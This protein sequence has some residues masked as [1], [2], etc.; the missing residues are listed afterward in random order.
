MKSGDSLGPPIDLYAIRA[1]MR[2]RTR[3]WGHFTVLRVLSGQVSFRATGGCGAAGRFTT[4]RSI[5]FA[6]AEWL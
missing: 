3:E 6:Q 1:G 2:G 5:L 4:T